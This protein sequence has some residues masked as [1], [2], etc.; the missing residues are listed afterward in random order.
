MS[1]SS[2]ARA[3]AAAR[4]V[5]GPETCEWFFDIRDRL[6]AAAEVVALDRL[7]R[8]RVVTHHLRHA[9]VALIQMVDDPAIERCPNCAARLPSH[10]PN[11]HVGRLLAHYRSTRPPP[12]R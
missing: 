6:S 10:G 2:K 3:F 5:V 4:D 8:A 12:P 7:E 1:S 11:C 9:L